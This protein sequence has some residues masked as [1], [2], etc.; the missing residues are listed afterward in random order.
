RDRAID[1]H[2]VQDRIQEQR[3]V[4]AV[5]EAPGESSGW[6]IWLMRV[7]SQLD[8]QIADLLLHKSQG[9]DHSLLGT[10]ELFDPA[11]APGFDFRGQRLVALV[12]RP[13]PLD[14]RRPILE[15]TDRHPWQFIEPCRS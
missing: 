8:S 5:A 15:F 11:I 10:R 6:W 4:L 7:R 13:R 14:H 3:L 2:V 12:Q 1:M 9:R